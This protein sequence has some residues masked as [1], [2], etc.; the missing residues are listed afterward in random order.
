MLQRLAPSMSTFWHT[1]FF[2]RSNW[3]LVP[4]TCAWTCQKED[5]GKIKTSAPA[6]ISA[7]PKRTAPLHLAEVL[8]LL[9]G[10]WVQFLGDI[11]HPQQSTSVLGSGL[12]HP[13]HRQQRVGDG[14]P[15]E[16]LHLLVHSVQRRAQS[17]PAGPRT[18]CWRGEFSGVTQHFFR[19]ACRL[20]S[21]WQSCTGLCWWRPSCSRPSNDCVQL[22]SAGTGQSRSPP[23]TSLREEIRLQLSTKYLWLV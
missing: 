19:C 3:L 1:S 12:F 22:E 11:F 17:H 8:Q 2:S 4:L 14:T 9:V 6:L 7:A 10:V 16:R 23:A 15:P 20:T 18:W 13:A 5:N 21:A